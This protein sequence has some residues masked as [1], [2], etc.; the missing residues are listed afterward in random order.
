M[1]KVEGE[2][3]QRTL[4]VDTLIRWFGLEE[5]VH[6]MRCIEAWSM[7]IP[8]L[9]FPLAALIQRLEADLTGEVRRGDDALRSDAATQP[10][11]YHFALALRR[12]LADGRGHAPAHVSGGRPLRCAAARSERCAAA[13]GVVH[14]YMRAKKDTSMPLAFALVLGVLLAVRLLAADQKRRVRRVRERLGPDV[15]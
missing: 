4:D 6:R 14:F 11:E 15:T 12:R 2:V 8:W 10:R 9:G 5:R 3:E 13:L 1:L 7:V